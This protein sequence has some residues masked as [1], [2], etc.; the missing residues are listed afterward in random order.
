MLCQVK[1]EVCAMNFVEIENWFENVS[2]S[3]FIHSIIY[4]VIGSLGILC[5]ILLLIGLTKKETGKILCWIC[6]AGISICH[7]FFFSFEVILILLHFE[8]HSSVIMFV[9]IVLIAWIVMEAYF[10]KFIILLCQE[11]L[12]R[13]IPRAP[14]STWRVPTISELLADASVMGESPPPVYSLKE[15]DRGVSEA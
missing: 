14:L 3:V 7:Q 1:Q 10:M 5:S 12:E 11:I 2:V 8:V 4:V 15:D 9:G 6:L 13:E